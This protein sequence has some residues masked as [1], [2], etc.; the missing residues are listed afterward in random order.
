MKNYHTIQKSNDRFAPLTQTDLKD[1]LKKQDDP[2]E[3]LGPA[4]RIKFSKVKEN[5]AKKNY[6]R[7]KLDP[8][9]PLEEGHQRTKP[10]TQNWR[11]HTHVEQLDSNF[12][13][14]TNLNTSLP[15]VDG[16]YL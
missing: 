10:G 4:D 12:G 1:I 14:K 2:Y 13:A 3:G 6:T 8:A 7:M 15:F 11:E 16:R 5:L 9:K